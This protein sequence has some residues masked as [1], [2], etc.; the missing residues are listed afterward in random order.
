MLKPIELICQRLIGVSYNFD[1][2][3]ARSL[4]KGLVKL[5]FIQSGMN[6]CKVPIRFFKIPAKFF[7]KNSFARIGT[8]DQNRVLWNLLK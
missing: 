2:F 4:V 5:D 7:G 8:M 6:D 3:I 1:V